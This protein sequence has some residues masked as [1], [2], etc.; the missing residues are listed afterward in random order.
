MQAIHRQIWH[1][2]NHTGQIVYLAKHFAGPNWKA[3]T[4]P[5]KKSGG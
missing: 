3:I 1:V 4:M 5:K 2:A